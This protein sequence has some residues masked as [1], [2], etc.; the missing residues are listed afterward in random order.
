MIF[1]YQKLSVYL[2]IYFLYTDLEPTLNSIPFYETTK[3]NIIYYQPGES[4]SRKI[5]TGNRQ[6]RFAYT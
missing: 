2:I 1:F 6:S 5:F 3:D 4:I